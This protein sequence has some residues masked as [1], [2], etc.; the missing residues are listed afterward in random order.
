MTDSYLDI[1]QTL[2]QL[3]EA[4]PESLDEMK[5]KENGDA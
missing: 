1:L 3:P 4:S 5:E 2:F